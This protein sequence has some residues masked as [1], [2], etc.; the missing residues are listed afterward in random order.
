M[1]KRP[2]DITPGTRGPGY[3]RAPDHRVAFV[4]RRA[5]VAV[6]AGGA[7]IADT[8]DVVVVEENNYPPRHYLARDG[9]DMSKLERTDK[10]TFCP[11]KGLATYYAIK[12]DG[13]EIRD[14]VWSYEQP[15]LEA[16]LLRDRL[17][18][19]AEVV[20]VSEGSG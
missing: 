5:T 18:F 12:T 11:F 13:G 10:I 17:A 19:D 7:E 8:D 4:P 20:D 6:S 15:Y 14:A 2:D 9:V 3:L 1:A 16:E